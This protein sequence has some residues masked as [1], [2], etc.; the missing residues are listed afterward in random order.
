[1]IGSATLLYSKLIIDIKIMSQQLKN[2][3]LKITIFFNLSYFSEYDQIFGIWPTVQI[4]NYS[5]QNMS[6][7]SEYDLYFS[8]FRIWLYFQNISYFFI[9]DVFDSGLLRERIGAELIDSTAYLEAAESLT[10]FTYV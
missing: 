3:S 10:T 1:M 8:V 6:Y 5:F 4:T 7:F 2:V 9:D